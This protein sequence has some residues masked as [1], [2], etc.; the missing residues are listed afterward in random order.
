MTWHRRGYSGLGGLPDQARP[1]GASRQ[2]QSHGIPPEAPSSGGIP[3]CWPA[4]PRLAGRPLR[5]P[6][7]VVATA[8]DIG[9]DRRELELA[10]D[11]RPVAG[12]HAIPYGYDIAKIGCDLNA[13]AVRIASPGLSPD[14]TRQ[15]SHDHSSRSQ[16][17]FR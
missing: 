16:S 13:A 8:L 2:A 14:G 9:N 6:L 4:V 12:S 15:I 11:M 5:R 10:H 7:D 1:P 3:C 17:W